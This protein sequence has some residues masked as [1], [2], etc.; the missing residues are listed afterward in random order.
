M[1][2]L[3]KKEEQLI[4]T[5][6]E[7]FIKKRLMDGFK[8]RKGQVVIKVDGIALA[9]LECDAANSEFKKEILINRIDITTKVWV[10]IGD[11][12][13]TNNLLMLSLNKQM[14]LRYNYDNDLYEIVNEDDLSLFDRT[15]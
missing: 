15:P 6:I 10:D 5:P 8:N 9:R 2:E 14:K 3:V 1:E 13:R 7:A 12:A 11:A 4:F